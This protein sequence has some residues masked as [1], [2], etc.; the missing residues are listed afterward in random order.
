MF[1]DTAPITLDGFFSRPDNVHAD[2]LT[3]TVFQIF[4]YLSVLMCEI[5]L[6]T[7]DR[8]CVLCEME[9]ANFVE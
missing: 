2:N 3:V 4:W 1:P 8:S 9:I 5:Q 7:T 6:A